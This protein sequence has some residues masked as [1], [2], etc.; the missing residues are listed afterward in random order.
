LAALAFR[1]GE[2]AARA[3]ITEYD[4]S[5]NDRYSFYDFAEEM[6]QAADHAMSVACKAFFGLG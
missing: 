5:S 2:A 4:Q 3:H 1:W 6:L